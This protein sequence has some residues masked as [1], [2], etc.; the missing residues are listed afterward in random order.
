MIFLSHAEEIASR[1]SN[2]NVESKI[3]V[4]GILRILSLKIFFIVLKKE[5]HTYKSKHK[6]N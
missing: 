6:S 2:K 5:K 3:S 1:Y 4:S